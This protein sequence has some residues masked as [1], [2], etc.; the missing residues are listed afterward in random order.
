MVGRTHRF[1]L[2]VEGEN[3]HKPFLLCPAR[4]LV[5]E[6]P[7]SANLPGGHNQTIGRNQYPFD[8]IHPHVGALKSQGTGSAGELSSL[9]ST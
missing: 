8:R 4:L 2:L 7:T 6:A 1:K 3:G 9:N 5:F